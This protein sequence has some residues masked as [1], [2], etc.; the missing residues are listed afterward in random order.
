M[1]VS[2]AEFNHFRDFA[3]DGPDRSEHTVGYG[4][5]YEGPNKSADYPEMRGMMSD[6][7]PFLSNIQG[8]EGDLSEVTRF[9][10]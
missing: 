2:Q 10:Q 9:R 7:L 5:H 1:G 8:M 6:P 3:V 4:F